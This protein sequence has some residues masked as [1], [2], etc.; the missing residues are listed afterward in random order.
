L[1]GTLVN[2]GSIVAGALI[3]IVL[4]KGIPDPVKNTVMQGL[5]LS[6][7]LIGIQMSIK[8]QNVL[9]VVISLVVG[10]VIGQLINIERRLASLGI[11]L[12][13]MMGGGE[14]K[15]ARAFVTSS[16]IYCVGAM[17]I[18]GSIEDGLTGNATTLY[19]KSMLDGVSA[20]I[21]SSTMGIG[22]L[23]SAVPVLLYQGAITLMAES[24]KNIFTP[25]VIR[26]L[27]ATGG[28]LIMGIGINI[29]EIK[30]IMVGNLLPSIVVIVLLVWGAGRYGIGI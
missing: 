17:A 29:L 5:G 12:E 1:T 19:A 9:L 15:A 3:G 7:L 23:F 16:L 26:E 27:T 28:L 21:F 14:G 8:T 13:V 10:G 2:V 25:D 22:V 24:M 30:E 18:L 11:R 4:R 6:V 20:V